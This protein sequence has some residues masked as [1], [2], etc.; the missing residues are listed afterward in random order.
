MNEA[1]TVLGE[2]MLLSHGA[3]IEEKISLLDHYLNYTTRLCESNKDDAN[4]PVL[5]FLNKKKS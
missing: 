2:I 4:D 3:E 5:P 1:S